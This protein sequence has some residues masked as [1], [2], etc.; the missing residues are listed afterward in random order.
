ML[1]LSC[2]GI[3]GEGDLMSR[4]DDFSF[5]IKEHLGILGAYSTGWKK[6]LNLIEWNGSNAKLDIRDWDPAHE[7]MSRGVTL[8]TDEARTL[9]SILEKYFS[10]QVNDQA[11]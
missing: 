4:G 8:H 5:E 11:E 6:E 10:R 3:S 1:K 7:R 2:K 9:L